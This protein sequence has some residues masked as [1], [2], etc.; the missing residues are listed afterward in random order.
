MSLVV[1]SSCYH[2]E[3]CPLPLQVFFSSPDGA[4]AGLVYK[5]EA[6]NESLHEGKCIAPPF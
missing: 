1:H 6:G 4:L 2:T 3:I 5:E